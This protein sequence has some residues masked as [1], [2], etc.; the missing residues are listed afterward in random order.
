MAVTSEAARKAVAKYQAKL[1]E[2][3][4]R[5]PKGEREKYKQHAEAKGM[6]LNQLII[7]LLDEDMKR[8]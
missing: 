5:V 6:S 1:D 3:K 8:G 2:I 4:V 7:K